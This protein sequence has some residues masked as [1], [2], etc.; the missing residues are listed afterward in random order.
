MQFVLDPVRIDRVGI[1]IRQT[2]ARIAARVVAILRR[3]AVPYLKAV[4]RLR[5]VRR[6]VDEF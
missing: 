3:L 6:L 5:G 2:A 1:R 4:A